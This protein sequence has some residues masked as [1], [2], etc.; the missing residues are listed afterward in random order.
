[1]IFAGDFAQLL[2]VAGGESSS[3][4]SLAIKSVQWLQ[5]RDLRRRQWVK[6]FG[7]R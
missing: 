4:Y 6:L 3:L 7:T 1:M 5:T 2:P